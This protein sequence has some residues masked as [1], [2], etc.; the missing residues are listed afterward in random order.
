MRDG[1]IKLALAFDA[2]GGWFDPHWQ[3]QRPTFTRCPCVHP[4]ASTSVTIQAARGNQNRLAH[5]IEWGP[6]LGQSEY[7]AHF[8]TRLLGSL[9][10]STTTKIRRLLAWT[11]A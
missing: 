4:P 7:R 8:C 11:F 1:G 6:T 3:D 10:Y 9:L 2:R 5:I